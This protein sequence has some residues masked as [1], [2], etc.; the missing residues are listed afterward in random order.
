M[1]C[2]G[3]AAG[4]LASSHG[5]SHLSQSRIAVKPDTA[6]RHP[7]GLSSTFIVC[8][9]RL[10]YRAAQA[11]CCKEVMVILAFYS[12]RAAS[13]LATQSPRAPTRLG[14]GEDLSPGGSMD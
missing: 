10:G 6:M 4:R 5:L 12:T 11:F 1:W 7:A 14:S 9:G 13:I 8:W 2:V 3:P